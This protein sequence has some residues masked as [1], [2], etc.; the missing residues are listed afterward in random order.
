MFY[1]IKQ[2]FITALF[3]IFANPLNVWLKRKFQKDREYFNA[4][5][6]IA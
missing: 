6:I 4:I 5:R 1:R 3:Y 2:N